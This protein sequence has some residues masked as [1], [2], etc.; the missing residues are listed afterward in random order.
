MSVAAADQTIEI[1]DAETGDIIEEGKGI[2]PPMDV[3]T[4]MIRKYNV[5]NT[6]VYPIALRDPQAIGFTLLSYPSDVIQPGHLAPA[7]IEVE[8]DIPKDAIV[9]PVG[10]LRFKLGIIAV[11]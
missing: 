2:V 5:R 11:G 3:G 7:P 8:F 9:P 4:S 1:T 6:G 10:R